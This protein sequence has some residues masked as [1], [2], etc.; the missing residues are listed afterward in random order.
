MWFDQSKQLLGSH[1][2]ITFECQ[3]VNLGESLMI[4][5]F[6]AIE[7]FHLKYSRFL[8]G[9]ILEEINA[10]I[11]TWQKVDEE[12]FSYLSR[13]QLFLKEYGLNFSLAVKSALDRIGYD[14]T[15]SFQEKNFTKSI[16]G[17]MDL[18]EGGEIFLSDPIEFGG[19]GK[20]HALDLAVE[21]LKDYCANICLD[22]GGDLYA[23]GVNE[24]GEPWIMALESPFLEGEAIGK[25]TL[26]G[27]FLAASGS[28][29]RKW[30]KNGELHHLIDPQK[31]TSADYWAG[32]FVQAQSGFLADS[33]ATALFC[34]DS[35]TL[36]NVN[37]KLS[38]LHYLI[39]RKDSSYVDHNFPGELFS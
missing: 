35:E 23:K 33:L 12:T 39:V 37:E 29:K 34:T 14:S 24:K 10:N 3:D 13:V 20:G 30:G 18:R 22:F 11:G 4:L 31:G 15:Y 5:T 9:N 16:S 32:V 7:A 36:R 8:H 21:V 25:I 19:F 27:G 26:N 28:L 38:D 2:R 17:V 6:D 1:L